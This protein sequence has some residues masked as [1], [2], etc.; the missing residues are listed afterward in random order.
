MRKTY[1]LRSPEAW[2][3]ASR[4][5]R[6]CRARARV[7]KREETHISEREGSR[8]GETRQI[9]EDF[10]VAAQR[11]QDVTNAFET[12]G[13]AR[14]C[15]RCQRLR[16]FHETHSE[17]TSTD[18]SPLC[19]TRPTTNAD[20]HRFGYVITRTHESRKALFVHYSQHLVRRRH[21]L[22]SPYRAT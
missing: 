11:L 22:T 18:L 7:E 12:L 4:R 10:E 21:Y 16:Y 19:R 2:A 14:L 8:K 1:S 13:P 9:R 5:Q 20:G 3:P 17:T 15:S 6:G